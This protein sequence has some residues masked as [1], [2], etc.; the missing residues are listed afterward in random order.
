MGAVGIHPM[1]V[2]HSMQFRPQESPA[3]RRIYEGAGAGVGTLRRSLRTSLSS[4][5]ASYRP[6]PLESS[7]EH[8]CSRGVGSRG[9]WD[10]T[11]STSLLRAFKAASTRIESRPTGPLVSDWGANSCYPRPPYRCHIVA[12]LE[13]SRVLK[14]TIGWPASG[15]MRHPAYQLLIIP[16]LRGWVNKPDAF[17]LCYTAPKF[18]ERGSPNDSR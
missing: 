5:A 8:V 7:L 13:E 6:G 16:L 3:N 10:L 9:P 11:G 18:E 17:V 15:A 2:D 12:D 4:F 1:A 14:T